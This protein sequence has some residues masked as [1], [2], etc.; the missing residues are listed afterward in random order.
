MHEEFM[1]MWRWENILLNEF[2]NWSLKM[3]QVMCCYQTPMMLLAM[4][5]AVKNA[6]R[7]RKE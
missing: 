3:P 5:I 6:K 1:V 4:G 7:Q 2:F